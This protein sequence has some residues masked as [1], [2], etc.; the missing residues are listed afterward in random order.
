MQSIVGW[1]TLSPGKGGAVAGEGGGVLSL[2]ESAPFLIG[3][4]VGG[5]GGVGIQ[6]ANPSQVPAG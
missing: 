3:W 2:E 5:R 4:Y 1:V 6:S